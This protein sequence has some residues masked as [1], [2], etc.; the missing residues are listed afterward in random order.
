VD[1]FNASKV[2]ALRV[3]G[4]GRAAQEQVVDFLDRECERIAALTEAA[5]QASELAKLAANSRIE[6]LLNE[7]AEAYP[8]EKVGWH[9]TMLTG[10]VFKS[11]EFVHDSDL[12]IRLLRGTNVAVG[13]TRWDDTVYWPTDRVP[14]VQEFALAVGDLVIGL[15]RPWI[16]D[17]LR[18]AEIA[19]TDLPALLLQRVGRVRP[20][21][22]RLLTRYLRLW[23]ETTRFQHEVGDASAVTFPM[24]EPRR[25]LAYRVPVP[26]IQ[27]QETTLRQAAETA[28][29]GEA[30]A[31]GVEQ[32]D[33]ALTEYRDALITEA[34]TG[35]L[36]VTRVSEQQLDESARAAMEGEKRQALSA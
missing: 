24:L 14:E 30:L 9:V 22:G 27:D 11:E 29:K 13:H 8:L 18:V 28:A 10:H 1:N 26:P 31:H 19:E 25:L 20:T 3:P 35:K 7:D 5:T 2:G 4:L 12:G 21:M 17:G 36:E 16:S 6:G 15:N 23:L 34:V 33:K 32:F